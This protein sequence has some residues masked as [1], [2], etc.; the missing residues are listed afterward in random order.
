MNCAKQHDIDFAVTVHYQCLMNNYVV[1]FQNLK[2]L[3]WNI[4]DG[5]LN[6][7]A[8]MVVSFSKAEPHHFIWQQPDSNYMGFK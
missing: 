5:S 2:M 3:L 8:A 1:N 6:R 7:R 4:Q